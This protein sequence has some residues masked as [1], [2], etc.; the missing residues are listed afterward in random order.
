M[1]FQHAGGIDGNGG[2]KGGREN[3]EECVV[4]RLT[5]RVKFVIVTA[6]AGDGQSLESFRY[7]IDLIV[8]ET[9][10]LIERIGRGKSVKYH[11]K[12]CRS[13]GA[14]VDSQF[15]IDSRILLE[16]SGDVFADQLIVGDIEVQR[17]N[18]IVPILP[19]V[20]DRRV[21][22]AAMGV[23][24]AKPIHPVA[25]PSFSECRRRE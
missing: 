1:Y 15:G 25:R 17:T 8:G 20:G 18:E 2:G 7:G 10:P 14:F 23:G 6:G 9:D 22:L 11:P 21:A 5:D 19:G 24:V 12:V 4:I 16:I 3:T 13:D